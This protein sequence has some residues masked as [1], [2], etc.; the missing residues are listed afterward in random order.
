MRIL[1]GIVIT[2]L[3]SSVAVSQQQTNNEL[4]AILDTVYHNEQDPI[5]AR[6]Q[7]MD[8]FGAESDSAQVYQKI[9]KGNHV[10]NERIVTG[11]LDEHGWL[12]SDV[13]GEQ[14]NTTLFLVIQHSDSLTRLKYLPMMREAVKKGNM[15]PRF[16]GNVEDRTASDFG[17]MQVYGNQVKYYRETKTFDVW[18]IVDPENVDERRA[19]IGL[20]PLAEHLKRRFKLDW[21]LEKQIERSLKFE[22][23]MV[24]KKE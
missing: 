14:G 3:C 11:I 18:P 13:V 1:L 4:I 23:E 7:M 16:L 12:G 22:A 2:G 21:D 6:D 19:T 5:R 15:P 8:K 17:E 20:G 24:E 9:Y 10:L